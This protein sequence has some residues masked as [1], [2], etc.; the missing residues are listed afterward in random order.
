MYMSIN[1]L[2]TKYHQ[3]P[4]LGSGVTRQEIMEKKGGKIGSILDT[5]QSAYVYRSKGRSSMM[6]LYTMIV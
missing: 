4:S 6:L 2:R 5:P 3:F 1:M